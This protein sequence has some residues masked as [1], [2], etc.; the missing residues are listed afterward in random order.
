MNIKSTLRKEGIK[1]IKQLDTLR[2]NS[3]ASKIANALC[4]TFPEHGFS[5][6]DLF[7][8]ICN[9]NM[10][11]ANFEDNSIGAKYFYKN[12]SIYFNANFDLDSI[13]M[14][15][16][17]ECIH[18]LQEK[19]D[20][21]G[22]LSHLGLYNLSKNYGIGLNE[23]A[24]QLMTSECLKMQPEE[25][26][27]Y[28]LSLSTSSPTNYPLECAL[29][30]QVCYFTG[31]YPLYHST[32]CCDDIFKNTFSTLSDEKTFYI[33]QE[34]LDRMLALENELD[35]YTSLLA[36]YENN[37]RKIRNLNNI[38]EKYR[39]EISQL[40][41]TTQNRIISYCFSKEFHEIKTLEA[42]TE[43]KNKLYNFKSLIAYNEAYTFYNEFY[44][45]AMEKLEEKRKE[46]EETSLS[47]IRNEITKDITVVSNA[48]GAFSFLKRIA[49]RLGISK[50]KEMLQ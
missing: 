15:S 14:F 9:L 4:S 16:L 38:I 37:I 2:I 42:I 36:H 24:V 13:D 35:Y 44:C 50:R 20:S 31:S 19:Y 32:L 28:N 41:L 40:F 23:A 49:Y 26:K 34:N 39:Q 45:K 43:F 8:E 27:Y 30:R 17:H 18:Y 21:R 22:K 33:V 10:Y 48:K 25:V 46:I 47:I 6:N 11:L 12:K 5:S 3:I 1:V 29:L 7:I